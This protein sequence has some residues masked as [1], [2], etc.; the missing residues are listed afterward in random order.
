[1]QETTLQRQIATTGIS[2]FAKKELQDKLILSRISDV[3]KAEEQRRTDSSVPSI[4]DSSC[5]VEMK[6]TNL[7]NPFEKTIQNLNELAD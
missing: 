6:K 3:G 5:E 7:V 1:M 2:P 4:S